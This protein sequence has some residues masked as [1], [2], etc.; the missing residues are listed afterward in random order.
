MK[1]REITPPHNPGELKRI[2]SRDGSAQ[3]RE[4]DPRPLPAPYEEAGV[5]GV[6]GGEEVVAHSSGPPPQQEENEAEYLSYPQYEIQ[7][8]LRDPPDAEPLVVVEFP[9]LS[10]FIA[11]GLTPVGPVAELTT[12]QTLTQTVRYAT[13]NN[14]D[15]VTHQL[16][17]VLLPTDA[18]TDAIQGEG[19]G[20]DDDDDD[21]F[22][23]N[24][25][26]AHDTPSE[27]ESRAQRNIRKAKK[28]KQA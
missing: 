3:K 5:S 4:V 23:L 25:D 10:E 2:R 9:D 15:S 16:Y 12:S 22:E 8:Y 17:P 18:I 7:E 13:Q 19:P 27:P 20:G 28:E 1:K 26:G 6:S 21:R 14:L 24:S 11:K